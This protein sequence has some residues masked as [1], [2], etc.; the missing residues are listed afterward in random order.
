[1]EFTPKKPMKWLPKDRRNP[2]IIVVLS[3]AAVLA[4]ISL[5]LIRS[6]NATLSSLANSRRS[7]S[8]KLQSMEST[9]K[10]ANITASQLAETTAALAAAEADMASGDLFSWSYTSMR[11]FKQA[12]KVEIPEIGHPEAGDVDMF[13]KFPYKQ[14]RFT[15]TGKAYYH[16]LGK[17]VSDFENIFPHARV[18]NLTMEPI[19]GGSEKLSFRMQIVELVK[20]NAS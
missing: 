19:V 3:T 11:Q 4:I 13:A 18:E 14:I 6:Q 15:L 8:D 17:F 10:N 9:I 20:P 7:A 2:F 16:D 5:G 12:Y 1:M